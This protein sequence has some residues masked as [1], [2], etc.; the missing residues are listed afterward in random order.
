MFILISKS[1][2]D[3]IVTL[4]E[5]R[6]KELEDKWRERKERKKKKRQREGGREENS[7]RSV[8]IGKLLSKVPGSVAQI[9][10]QNTAAIQ[11]GTAEK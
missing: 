8:G 3:V 7:Q 11:Q 5:K 9:E 2:N 1:S 10:F 4:S 6:K